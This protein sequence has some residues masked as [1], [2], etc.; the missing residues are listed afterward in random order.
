MNARYFSAL[1]IAA[2][3]FSIPISASAAEYHAVYEGN[4]TDGSDPDNLFGVS[5]ND[6]VGSSVKADITYSTSIPGTRMTN[7]TSD[8]LSGGDSFL[9]DPVI[10]SGVFTIG[11]KR[12]TVLPTY[13]SDVY[14]SASYLDAYGYDLLSNSF[15]TYIIP[16]SVAPVN[17]ETPFSSSG[18]GDQGG[19][20][21]QYSYLATGND[22][23][24]F[25]MTNVTV[26]AVP[27]ISTW[28]LMMAG[29]GATGLSLRRRKGVTT[30][31]QLI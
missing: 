28:A 10:L 24:D 5:T 9:T 14:T 11:L 6:F 20:F 3:S 12:I 15:Q 17:L 1:G 27:E 8:E 7:G 16:N 31:L 4:I 2:L 13:Y 23:I 21:T 25:D 26:S 29:I 18:T 30:L 22:L 19:R